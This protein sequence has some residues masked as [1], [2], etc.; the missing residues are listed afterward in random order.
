MVGVV[1]D[2]DVL[3]EE[4]PAHAVDQAGARRRHPRRARPSPTQRACRGARP[5]AARPTAA[6][7]DSPAPGRRTA[8]RQ[9]RGASDSADVPLDVR[10]QR[11]LARPLDRGREL[12]LMARAHSRQPAGENLAALGEE[13]AERA[14]VLVVEHPYPGFAHGARLGGPSHASS[15]S[16]S[17]TTTSAAIT[18][19][20][21][22]GF[23]GRPS[24][25]TTRKRSTPS[26][27]FT[28]RSYSGKRSAAVSNCATT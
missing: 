18:A 17:S 11:E 14:I 24:D 4:L 20:A 22:S 2:G 3:S 1:G 23:A 15:S 19:G 21:G 26:S 6:P 5:R 12:A 8:A 9:P 28:A 16:I 25:T 13:A 7:P 10:Q 27:S